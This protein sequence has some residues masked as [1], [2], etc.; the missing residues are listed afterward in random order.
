MW[1][2]IIFLFILFKL[3]IFFLDMFFFKLFLKGAQIG[4]GDMCPP[5]YFN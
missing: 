5:R 1:F 3:G 2:Q 4:A